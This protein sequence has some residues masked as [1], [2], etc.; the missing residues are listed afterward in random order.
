MLTVVSGEVGLEVGMVGRKGMLGAHLALGVTAAPLHALVQGP[1]SAW[2][3]LSRDRA[4]ARPLAADE[5]GPG[6]C[7]Q[8]L[9]TQEFLSFMPGVRRVGI[10]EATGAL[11]RAGPIEYQRGRLT[12]LDRSGLEATACSCYATDSKSYA[13]LLS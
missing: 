9:M 2:R 5:P 6:A 3:P 7:R 1:A 8:F 4:E 12:V 11:Q 13:G 10:T